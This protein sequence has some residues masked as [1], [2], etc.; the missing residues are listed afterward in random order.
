MKFFI[1]LFALTFSV[2]SYGQVSVGLT[3]GLFIDPIP[4]K[5]VRHPSSH[6][7]YKIGGEVLVKLS[8]RWKF[9]T[10]AE[11]V[12]FTF[13]RTF[14]YTDQFGNKL[15]AADEYFTASYIGIPLGIRY[16][17]KGKKVNPFLDA[18]VSSMIKVSDKSKV[19]NYPF[20]NQTTDLSANAFIVSPSLGAGL[21]YRPTEKIYLSFLLNYNLQLMNVYDYNN[22]RYNSLG[23]ILSGGYQF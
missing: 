4:D 10:G 15:G 1:F 17:F 14:Q 2:A 11:Y 16:E 20:S 5:D 6:L 23:A 18:S 21:T 3:G 8:D 7:A 19:Q 22:T 12:S 13:K 9:K